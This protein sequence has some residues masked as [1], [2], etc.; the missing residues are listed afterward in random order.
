MGSSSSVVS[1]EQ[2]TTWVQRTLSLCPIVC[3]VNEEAVHGCESQGEESIP[4]LPTLS[5]AFLTNPAISDDLVCYS[6]S[7]FPTQ[8]DAA[9][10]I[11][12]YPVPLSRSWAGYR[13]RSLWSSMSSKQSTNFKIKIE[14]KS[15]TSHCFVFNLAQISPHTI[16]YLKLDE[17]NSLQP[18]YCVLIRS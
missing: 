18:I 3:C 6:V 17:W 15:H 11:L 7:F 5:V 14:T 12:F 13:H 9:T 8:A 1:W 16:S 2:D 4:L 10:R